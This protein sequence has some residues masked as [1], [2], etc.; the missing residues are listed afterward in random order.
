MSDL[1]DFEK[2][3]RPV[4]AWS[5]EGYYDKDALNAQARALVDAAVREE[6]EKFDD[7]AQTIAEVERGHRNPDSALLNLAVKL[8]AER[9]SHAPLVAA[10]REFQEAQKALTVKWDDGRSHKAAVRLLALPLPEA[11]NE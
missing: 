6:R 5:A 4:H 11:P 7:I 3:W 8:K 1:L 2:V 10:V 9:E